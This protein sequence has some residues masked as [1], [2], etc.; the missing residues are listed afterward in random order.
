[1]NITNTENL[2]VIQSAMVSINFKPCWVQAL[3]DSSG[4]DPDIAITD[5][6]EGRTIPFI[7]STR[8]EVEKEIED[9]KSEMPDCLFRP[10]LV[11]FD[12]HITVSYTHLTLPTIYS[13]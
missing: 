12:N 6:E 2:T 5:D 10:M 4:V 9:D 1:M 13:V 8:A 11:S 3:D 7:Q